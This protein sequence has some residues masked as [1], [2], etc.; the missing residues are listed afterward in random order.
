MECCSALSVEIQCTDAVFCLFVTPSH[1]CVFQFDIG[2]PSMTKCCNQHDRCYDT[3]G[4]EK[5]DCDKQFQGC[6]ETICR[7]VQRTLGLSQSVQGKRTGQWLGRFIYSCTCHMLVSA[8]SLHKYNKVRY[9]DSV[10]WWQLYQQ[11]NCNHQKV[12]IFGG[13]RDSAVFS[14]EVFVYSKIMSRLII[15][16]TE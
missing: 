13:S 10:Q 2:I 1:T 6:L 15:K 8:Q 7:N 9:H 3:C 16:H 4:R 11:F 14:V 12:H 5:H